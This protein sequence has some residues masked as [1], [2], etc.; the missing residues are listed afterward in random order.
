MKFS[1]KLSISGE[2]CRFTNYCLKILFIYGIS[3]ACVQ[4]ESCTAAYV[5]PFLAQSIAVSIIWVESIECT[6]LGGKAEFY[7][8]L[9]TG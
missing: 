5:M 4:Y 6:K 3:A 9:F 8:D 1:F 2:L 7:L